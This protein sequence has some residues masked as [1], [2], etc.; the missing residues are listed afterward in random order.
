MGL[1]PVANKGRRF[2]SG[3]GLPIASALRHRLG[4]RPFDREALV[5]RFAAGA[6]FADVGCMWQVD[7]RIAF[8]AEQSG[9]TGVTGV[10]LMS[11]TPEFERRRQQTGSCVR[12]VQGDLHEQAVV[13]E[14]G[15]HDVV[16]CSGLIYH[17]PNPLLTLRALRA[18]TARTLLL[19]SE[20]VRERRR[21]RTVVFAPDPEEHPAI[22]APLDPAAGYN[23]W[24]WGITPSALR[25]MTEA[26]GFVVTEAHGTRRYKLLVARPSG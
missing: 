22:G 18:L 14:V 23:G 12:F 21:A 9:A 10:D 7:G 4:P 16:W 5:R 2:E 17:A 3:T 25:A 13:D 24:W 1:G 20:V 6:S 8:L 26:A 19:G 15:P 11:A